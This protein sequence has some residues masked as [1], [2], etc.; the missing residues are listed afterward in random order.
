MIAQTILILAY[1][2]SWAVKHTTLMC[3]NINKQ[4]QHEKSHM[5][6]VTHMYQNGSY[7]ASA[8]KNDMM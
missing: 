6:L 1:V 8:L 5:V 2:G 4:K 7:Y 3:F